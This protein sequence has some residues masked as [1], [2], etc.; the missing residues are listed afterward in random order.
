VEQHVRILGI[1]HIVLAS[2]GI[3][4]ALFM[5]ALFGGAA[6]LIG[7]AAQHDPAA[8]IAVPVVGFIGGAIFLFLVLVSVPGI[9]A[10][11]G[12]LKFQSWS[13]ILG[14]VIS[15]LQLFNVPFGTALGIYGLWVLLSEDTRRLFECQPARDD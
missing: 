1:L 12:L 10:G 9:V 4:A 8:G 13:R 11:I 15:A 5:L 3:L 14:I 6:S 7:I 2:L